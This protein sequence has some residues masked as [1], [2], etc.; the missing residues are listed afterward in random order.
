MT[1]TY[2]ITVECGGVLSGANGG[3][4]YLTA[5]VLPGWLTLTDHGDATGFLSG[6]PLVADIYPVELLM[7]DTTGLTASQTF[8]IIVQ[9][10]PAPPGSVLYLPLLMK[11][12][13][14]SKPDLVIDSLSVDTGGNAAVVIRN[15][16]TR[17]AAADFWVDV[18]IEPTTQP[19][20]ND[21]WDT[22]AA[23]GAAW[24]VTADLLPSQTL[25]LTTGGVYFDAGKSDLGGLTA[26]APAWA[27]V[28][29]VNHATS[30]GAVLESN[31]TNN[32]T[33]PVA[34][35]VGTANLPEAAAAPSRPARLPE[36]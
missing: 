6:A 19:E 36:R 23:K 28:D 29:S 4:M 24:G 2:A 34:V 26:G 18:Y 15:R 10:A 30:Y 22:I 1:Y 5:P 14:D 17:T 32:L 21:P 12:P 35:Q 20:I 33:G 8:S 3:G 16:G 13:A 31:E 7:T 11:V 9:P 25:T 27:L